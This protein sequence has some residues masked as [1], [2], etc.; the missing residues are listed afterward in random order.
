MG[1]L[2]FK[3]FFFIYGNNEGYGSFGVYDSIIRDKHCY[4][5]YDTNRV[6]ICMGEVKIIAIFNVKSL[7]RV[8][9]QR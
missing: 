4:G 7:D 8:R 1:S 6:G 2:R 5:L 9:E 3:I